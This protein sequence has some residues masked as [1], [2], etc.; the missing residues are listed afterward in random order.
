MY[1]AVRACALLVAL[2]GVSACACLAAHPDSGLRAHTVDALAGVTAVNVG[3][4]FVVHD[5]HRTGFDGTGMQ[6]ES[7]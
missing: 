2:V 1:S 3:R 5:R 7:R 6:S 4:A